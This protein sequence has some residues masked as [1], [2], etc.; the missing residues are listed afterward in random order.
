[1][2]KRVLRVQ[3][4][5]KRRQWDINP[6]TRIE[7]SDKTYRRSAEKEQVR[8][9]IDGELS[10][11]KKEVRGRILGID[12]GERRLGLSVSDPLGIIAQGLET[13]RRT[14]DEDVFLRLERLIEAHDIRKIVVGLPLS[15]TGGMGEKAL[16]VKGFI[17]RLEARFGLPV[18]PWDERMTTVQAHRTMHEMGHKAKG[19][20]GNIDRMAAIL[21][22]QNYLD[23]LS[24]DK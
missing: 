1:M 20:K 12:Y 13:L 2:A 3:K 9:E 15:L 19:A 16:E 24:K 18:V 5:K 22:L 23:S 6:I 7:E 8:D 4:P 10:R 11:E 14:T 21:I 17:D